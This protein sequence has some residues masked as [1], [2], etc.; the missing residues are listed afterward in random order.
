MTEMPI[1]LLPPQVATKIAAGEVVERP[2]SVVKELIEN[3]IDA[4]ATVVSVE[5][6]QGG[7]RLIR[8]SDNGSGIPQEDTFLAFTRHATSKISSEEDLGRIATLGFRGEALASIAAVAQVTML[9]QSEGEDAGTHLRVEAGETVRRERYGGTR[10]TILT[11]ENLFFNTPARLKFLRTESTESSHIAKLVSAYALAYPELRFHLTDNG[12]TII[13]TLGT[14]KLYDVLGQVFQTDVVQQMLALQPRVADDAGQG[15]ETASPTTEDIQVTGYIGAP[16]VH[17]A[18]RD[19]Q[20][21]FVNRRWIQDRS[22]SFALEEA[23]RT[24]LPVGRFPV[25]VLSITMDP[26]DLDV[27]VHPTKREVR[28]REP[29]RVFVALQRAVRS[30]IIGQAPVP[31]LPVGPT[32]VA[33]QSW[34]RR[35]ALLSPEVSGRSAGQLALDVQRTA[36]D[37]EGVASQTSMAERLPML[38]VLG[39]VRQ[40]YIIAEG[41]EGLYLIDQHAAHERVL[42]DQLRIAQT[43]MSISSQVLL[44]PIVVEL[45]PSQ[46]GQLQTLL[47]SLAALGFDI[48]PFGGQSCL[49]RAIPA[50]LQAENLRTVIGELLDSADEAGGAPISVDQTL[51]IVAC[52]AAVRAGQTLTLDE[53]RDLVRQLEKASLPYTCPHGR[54]TMIHLS[55]AQLERSFS[56]R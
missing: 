41:P 33:G 7:R 18:T 39:Q 32:P 16:S 56:R 19:Y 11:V 42:F 51:T 13:Q 21:V 28:F 8:V 20:M 34:E 9:T 55:S 31:S 6:R 24:L 47:E 23:Y 22:L 26:G 37:G 50:T 36:D 25:G 27:N 30:T 5:I 3:A 46:G 48:A 49:V 45:P 1:R 38:R 10:G 53:A 12:R 35:F 29:R 40:T 52:H 17:R 15:S 4:G 54:P 44:E 14:G 2:A 43:T